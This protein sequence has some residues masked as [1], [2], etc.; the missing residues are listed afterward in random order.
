MLH[1][2]GSNLLENCRATQ[3][4][5]A[6]SKVTK[7]T[8]DKLYAAG[9]LQQVGISLSKSTQHYIYEACLVLK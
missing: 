3:E 8:K 4:S 6:L 9:K 5:S 7:V 2:V 1:A